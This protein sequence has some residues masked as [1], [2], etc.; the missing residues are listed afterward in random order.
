M[1]ESH[2]AAI[3]A[4]RK[5]EEK[6]DNYL[7]VLGSLGKRSNPPPSAPG[8]PS[9]AQAQT[10]SFDYE[11]VK[12]IET[13]QV[14]IV[15]VTV[16]KDNSKAIMRARNSSLRIRPTIA[17][18]AI[19][20]GQDD[21]IELHRDERVVGRF[22]SI[23]FCLGVLFNILLLGLLVAIA[24]TFAVLQGDGV[25]WMNET[26]QSLLDQQKFTLV[27]VSQSQGNFAQVFKYIL[28]I[29]CI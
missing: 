15:P 11:N 18:V 14:P 7:D 29:I 9:Y 6:D 22:T 27:T 26:G 19:N 1:R 16:V 17:D 4:P 2:A 28:F 5:S 21:Y 13:A 24:I 20:V 10:S 3:N 25:S 8:L 23:S 12:S